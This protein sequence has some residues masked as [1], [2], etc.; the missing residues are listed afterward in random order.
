MFNLFGSGY[1]KNLS[2]QEKKDARNL[3]L[4]QA[5]MN[6][7]NASN[8]V[9]AQPNN[10]FTIGA[11]GLGGY[12]QGYR[13]YIDDMNAQKQQDVANR[14][15]EAEY[16]QMEA[17]KRIAEA[18]R[19]GSGQKKTAQDYNNY[20]IDFLG[21]GDPESA[22]IMQDMATLSNGGMTGS[23]VTANVY[24]QLIAMGYTPEEALRTATMRTVN[25][26]NGGVGAFSPTSLLQQSSGMAA[27]PST[28]GAPAG[29]AAGMGI[30]TRGISNEPMTQEQ[31]NSMVEAY[32][33]GRG[34]SPVNTIVQPETPEAQAERASQKK[35][36]ETNAANKA[37]A[38]QKNISNFNMMNT[39]L[40][41]IDQKIS[42]VEN[43]TGFK[44]IFGSIDARTPDLSQDA[45]TAASNLDALMNS[46]EIAGVQMMRAENKTGGAVGSMAV[47]EW[48]K[49]RAQFPNIDRRQDAESARE[50]LQALRKAIKEYRDKLAKAAG[51]NPNTEKTG[52]PNTSGDGW[53]IKEVK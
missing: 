28:T 39:Y 46:L 24:N 23:S 38:E 51:V 37:E 52:E 7:I 34:G 41:D 48:P 35:Y 33:A 9:G 3:G 11:A 25:L 45:A 1:G 4:I 43:A 53:G 10:I 42:D 36:A 31:I 21:A 40:Q 17:R 12:G 49:L 29:G 19:A 18:I 47:Q 50:H 44:S 32:Q 6:M 13:S 15:A 30:D 16:Q 27:P 2:E 20:A 14:R 8:T 22:R 26:P 5:G